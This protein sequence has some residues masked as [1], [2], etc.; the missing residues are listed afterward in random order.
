M[1]KDTK[2]I[3]NALSETRKYHLFYSLIPISWG[4]WNI[5]AVT[6]LLLFPD[7]NDGIV[8]G[9]TM[10]SAVIC[11]IGLYRHFK[12]RSGFILKSVNDMGKV[13]LIIITGIFIL[14]YPA[15]YFSNRILGEHIFTIL[16]VFIGIGL[17]ITGLLVKS[18]SEILIGLF[19]MLSSIVYAKYREQAYLIHLAV[20]F[21]TLIFIPIT[22]YIIKRDNNND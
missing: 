10:S 16:P 7:A 11:Q 1:K 6:I 15:D 17:A 22:D 18:R 4:F 5:C 21:V 8:W 19:W 14:L 13:W 9:T 20:V 12:S 3:R 2:L